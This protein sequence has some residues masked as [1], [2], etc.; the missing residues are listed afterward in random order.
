MMHAKARTV[1]ISE[2]WIRS[3]PMGHELRE[4]QLAAIFSFDERFQNGIIFHRIFSWFYS[5]CTMWA[6]G[7]S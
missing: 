2:E 5:L 4:G 3:I 6:G 7:D 1:P